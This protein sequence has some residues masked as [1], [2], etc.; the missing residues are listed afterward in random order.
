MPRGAA[1]AVGVAPLDFG[2]P[3][4]PARAGAIVGIAPARVLLAECKIMPEARIELRS[5]ALAGVSINVV[6][7]PSGIL[8][9]LA[10]PTEAAHRALAVAVDRARL[11]LGARGIVVRAERVVQ[12]GVTE[13]RRRAD[14]E[15][16]P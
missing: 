1:A 3:G 13:V 5:G 10:A 7:D 11:L 14:R 9:R 6:V 2:Q 4:G 12:T 8:L 16:G 15:H